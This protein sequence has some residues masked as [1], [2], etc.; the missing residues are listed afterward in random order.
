MGQGRGRIT[1]ALLAAAL[2]LGLPVAPA[3]SGH[4]PAAPLLAQSGQREQLIS[5]DQAAAAA[6]RA[7]GGRVL[8]VELHRGGRPWYRVKV[9]V[10]GERVRSVRVDARSGRVRD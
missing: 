8:R 4:G 2:A 10:D 5:A 3:L 7:T 6:R 1:A 9:L